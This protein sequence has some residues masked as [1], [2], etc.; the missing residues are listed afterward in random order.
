MH[1]LRR[2]LLAAVQSTPFEGF[3]R[4]LYGLIAQDRGTKYDRETGMVM[5]RVLGRKSN[6]I[7]IGAYRGA[8]DERRKTTTSWNDIHFRVV[9]GEELDFGVRRRWGVELIFRLVVNGTWI[10]APTELGASCEREQ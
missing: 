4:R 2:T 7:D 5:Q 9:G 6:C 1:R 3:A 10:F 8:F